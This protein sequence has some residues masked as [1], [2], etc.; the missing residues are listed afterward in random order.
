MSET[1]PGPTADSGRP[2]LQQLFLSRHP[3]YWLLGLVILVFAALTRLPYGGLLVA[4]RLLGG[5]IY[6][7][8]GR[9]K[10]I[11]AANVKACF[12]SLDSVAQHSLVRASFSELGIALVETFKVWF[13]DAHFFY[14]PRTQLAGE[15]H[16]QQALD[17]GKGIILLSCHYGSLDLNATLVGFHVRK[18]RKY[19]F[20]YRKPSDVMVNQFLVEKRTPYS[21]HFFPVN[22]LVGIIRLLK[23]QGVVWY[24]PDIEVKNKNAVF[25]DFMGVA[26]S[27]TTGLSKLAAAGNA[28]VLPFAH[29]RNSDNSYT[30]RFFAPLSDFPSADPVADTT[31]IN[32]A[33]ANIIQPFPERYWWSIKRFKHRPSGQASIYR[34]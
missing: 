18:Q 17:T 4:G 33:I 10:R 2:I 30:L 3:K 14:E 19:A 9:V 16:W 23:K 24:A 6:L 20:T 11:A 25:A 34:S 26:A 32:Q 5:L 27:T 31:Q 15:E 28:L 21:D 12:P 29:Y 7:L 8:G 13:G 22:N 1:S